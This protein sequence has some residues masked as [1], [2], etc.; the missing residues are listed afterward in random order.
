MD[1]IINADDFGISGEANAAIHWLHEHE[2][3][4]SAS[5]MAKCHS[6]KDAVDTAK[7]NPTLGVGVHLCL[8]GPHNLGNDYFT[9]ID[10]TTGEFYDRKRIIRKIIRFEINKSELFREYCLQIE[11]VLDHGI[12]IS[13]L[14]H[15]HHLHL[16]LPVLNA[17]ISAARKYKIGHIRS[18]KILLPV[19][20]NY[21][22]SL[23]RETHQL[24]LRSRW[25]TTNGH[26]EPGIDENADFE[27]QLKRLS[28]LT[29]LKDKTVEIVLH[30]VRKDDPE[31]RFFMD[32]RV[33][34][35]LKRT[36]V[37][38]YNDLP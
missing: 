28:D 15:H 14:D 21:L 9:L 10:E 25:H 3:V 35:L 20:K 27:L 33:R 34:H 16:Y 36:H 6:F 19:H 32:E 12:F 18:Q 31:T 24:Y 29:G 7:H 4:S 2:I 1:L 22:N 37:M 8:D 5:I 26:F 30:P 13:H 11:K 23:Y 38:N 17:M